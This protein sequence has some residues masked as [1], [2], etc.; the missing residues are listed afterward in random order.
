[1]FNTS[2][3]SQPAPFTIGDTSRTLPDVRNPGIADGALSLFKNTYFGAEN[4]YNLQIRLEE[5]D[6]LNHMQFGA[7]NAG[8]Q[9]G[10]SFGAVT[11]SGV[12]ARQAQLAAKFYW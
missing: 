1:M 11:S 4:R 7:P 6:A 3:F 9:S 12:S 2:V 10:S 5:F 8:I